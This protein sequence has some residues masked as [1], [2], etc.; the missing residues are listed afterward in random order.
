MKI[1]PLFISPLGFNF[2]MNET[3]EGDKMVG[4]IQVIKVC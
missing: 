4:Y 1:L 3:P 2:Y